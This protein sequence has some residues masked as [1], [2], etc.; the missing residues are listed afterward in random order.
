MM[1]G[2]KSNEFLEEISL[3][4]NGAASFG[5]RLSSS[6]L[7]LFKLYLEELWEWSRRFNLTGL[8]TRERIVIEL[9][10]DSLIPAPFLPARAT[11]LDVGSGAGFPGLP[12]KIR[13][14]GLQAYLLEANSK[15]A[16]FLKQVTRMLELQGVGVIRGR[17]EAH[18]P[19]PGYEVITARAVASLNRTLLWCSPLLSDGGILVVFL[20][21]EGEKDMERSEG[22]LDACGLRVNRKISYILPGRKAQRHTFILERTHRRSGP[23]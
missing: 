13:Q 17:V 4:A 23:S 6:E 11:M 7:R 16:G 15:K 21:L 2:E 14:P 19:T 22:V 20:G 12:L 3:L 1:S 10:L 9:F 8:K 18:Q 5:I